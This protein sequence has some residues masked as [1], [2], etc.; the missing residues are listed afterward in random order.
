MKTN[1]NPAE[2]VSAISPVEK[3]TTVNKVDAHKML[4]IVYQQLKQ[5][6]NDQTQVNFYQQDA[7]TNVLFLSGGNQISINVTEGG[8]R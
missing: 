2:F 8:E 3:S 6:I 4:L 7:E 1:Q 5:A